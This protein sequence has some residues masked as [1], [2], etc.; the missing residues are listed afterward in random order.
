MPLKELGVFLCYLLKWKMTLL[1]YFNKCISSD[2]QA[3]HSNK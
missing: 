1:H 2:L 3:K